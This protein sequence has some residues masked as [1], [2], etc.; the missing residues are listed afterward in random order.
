M[1][2]FSGG[3]VQ[4]DEVR[5]DYFYQ[6]TTL[7]MVYVLI[8]SLVILTTNVTLRGIYSVVLI[9][10]LT[11]FGL[12]LAYLNLWQEVFDVIPQLSVHM[13]MG[14]YIVFS[15]IVF[16]MWAAVFFIFDRM[17]Y[18]RISAGQLTRENSLSGGE[19]SYDA[20]GMLFEQHGDDFLRHRLLGLGSGDLTL[21]VTGAKSATIDVPNVL[22]AE[23]KVKA[24][25]R[26]IAV[27]PDGG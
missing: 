8:L 9:L 14:F 18:Y 6:N 13:N 3:T 10:A 7:G 22:F 15:T 11:I 24:I 27:E 20:R 1:T 19:A 26:L 16:I 5:Q 21:T 23:R 25:Q 12:A 17:T 4:L 2:Y